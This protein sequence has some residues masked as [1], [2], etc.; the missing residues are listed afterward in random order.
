M[1]SLRAYF[2]LART[3]RNWRLLI[4]NLRRGGYCAGGPILEKLVFWNG[5]TIVHPKNRGGLAAMLLETWYYNAYRL[6]DFYRPLPSD[7]VI[8]V[9][10]HVGLFTL[11][12]L[13]GEPR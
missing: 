11:R 9:G 12:V 2:F 7:M 8:D 6:G 3:F 5:E 13:R 1:N 10:A 4:Q